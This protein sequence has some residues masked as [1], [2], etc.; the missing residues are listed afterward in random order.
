MIA[1]SSTVAFPENSRHDDG[2][3]LKTSYCRSVFVS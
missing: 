2:P 3:E 1:A